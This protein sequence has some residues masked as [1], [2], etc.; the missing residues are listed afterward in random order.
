MR[1]HDIL[2]YMKGV[3]SMPEIRPISEL[4]NIT[5]ISELCH[6]KYEP[7]F[8]TKDGHVDLVVMSVETYEILRGEH[9]A[10]SQLMDELAKG[11]QSAKEMGLIP[12]E[13]VEKQLGTSENK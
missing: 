8:L 9:K 7:V 1:I 10:T 6:S 13:K 12:I 3:H 2:K 4:Q 5:E 11:E